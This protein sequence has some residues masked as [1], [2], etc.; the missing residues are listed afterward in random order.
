MFGRPSGQTRPQPTDAFPRLDDIAALEYPTRKHLEHD[1]VDYRPH[2][3]HE[4]RGK[5][6]PVARVRVH[7]AKRR[8][9]ACCVTGEDRLGLEDRVAVVEHR[10]DRRGRAPGHLL[11]DR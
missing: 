3:L 2:R 11:V 6:S 5:G 10:V 7:Q 9:E 4:I 8:I 1:L